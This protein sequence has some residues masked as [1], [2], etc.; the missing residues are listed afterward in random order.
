MAW[1][2]ASFFHAHRVTGGCHPW[3]LL[4]LHGLFRQ[5]S[6][7]APA[8]ATLRLR[9]SEG[10]VWWVAW[11][12]SLSKVGSWRRNDEKSIRTCAHATTQSTCCQPVVQPKLAQVAYGRV[13]DNLV[14]QFQVPLL[15]ECMGSDTKRTVL[16]WSACNASSLTW[17]NGFNQFS[18]QEFNESHALNSQFVKSDSKCITMSNVME[19]HVHSHPWIPH[20]FTYPMLIVCLRTK[21][22]QMVKASAFRSGSGAVS[23]CFSWSTAVPPNIELCFVPSRKVQKTI[24]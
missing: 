16:L 11:R 24:T 21:R 19:Q 9:R 12:L 7:T 13:P 15:R 6:K 20:H 3:G 5:G 1:L 2:L 14:L 23:V 22:T 8:V 10:F 17:R 18:H 4:G